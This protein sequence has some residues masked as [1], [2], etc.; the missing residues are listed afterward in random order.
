MMTEA[1]EE[2][3]M[4]VAAAATRTRAQPSLPVPLRAPSPSRFFQ[5]SSSRASPH[6]PLLPQPPSLRA[7][8]ATHPP[9]NGLRKE[10][11]REGLRA[12]AR[13]A[14]SS[15]VRGG[16]PGSV[17]N[18]RGEGGGATLFS[19]TARPAVARC[20]V[21]V[22][23]APPTPTAVLILPQPCLYFSFP[24]PRLKEEFYKAPKFSWYFLQ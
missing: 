22:A 18:Q 5:A 20:W 9:S 24:P 21:F 11:A 17:I 4:V 8:K 7:P 19:P 14:V 1:V 16:V 15:R 2:E 3:V 6:R 10:R 13:R 23:V 12:H